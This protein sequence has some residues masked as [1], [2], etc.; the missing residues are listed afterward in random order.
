M[1]WH[2]ADPAVDGVLEDATDRAGKFVKPGL[3]EAK[4]H[5][6]ESS[7]S[8]RTDEESVRLNRR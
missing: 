5:C 7:R 8:Q 1:L 2:L 6:Q 3:Q 4:T